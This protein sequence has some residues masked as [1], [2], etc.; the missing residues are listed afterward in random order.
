MKPE[1]G[2]LSQLWPVAWQPWTK[3]F[4]IGQECTDLTVAF[5]S[6]LAWVYVKQKG[7]RAGSAALCLCLQNCLVT[8]FIH[9][10]LP[11]QLLWPGAM[12]LDQSCVGKVETQQRS[13]SQL[14]G[15][16]EGWSGRQDQGRAGDEDLVSTLLFPAGCGVSISIWYF[17]FQECEAS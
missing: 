13:S 9:P 15:A 4:C 8:Y 10:L 17:D 7:G 14:T 12:A 11:Q 16:L 5:L 3:T 6:L 2:S 1:L